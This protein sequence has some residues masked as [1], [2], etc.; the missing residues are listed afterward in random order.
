[1]TDDEKKAAKAAYMK[2]WRAA[3]PDKVSAAKKRRSAKPEE[4]EAARRRASSW[5]HRSEEN[6]AR[7]KARNKVWQEANR[8]RANAYSREWHAKQTPLRRRIISIKSKYQLTDEQVD[9]IVS[10]GG[11]CDSCGV[12]P[13]NRIDHDHQTGQFRGMLCHGCNVAAGCLKDDPERAIALSAYLVRVAV[14]ARRG[15]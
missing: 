7:M 1:M 4:Q 6:K 3:N 2:A 5:Y 11:I 12:E 13:G 10:H 9:L 8:E 14:T 15:S